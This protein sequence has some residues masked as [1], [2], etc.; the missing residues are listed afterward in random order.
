[1]RLQTIVLA[2]ML[3]LGSIV[4]ADA[5]EPLANWPSPVTSLNALTGDLTLAAG[6]N[7]TLT[8]SGSTL[9]IASTGGTP[10]GPAGGSLSGTYPNPGIADGAV[11]DGGSRR[12]RSVLD[13][14]PARGRQERPRN[15]PYSG[16]T[17]C[18]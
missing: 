1:M 14:A 3:T 6:S 16:S 2:G 18:P 10:T 12:W 7:V 17:S 11:T 13:R 8:P 15:P 4:L 5:D 9:T